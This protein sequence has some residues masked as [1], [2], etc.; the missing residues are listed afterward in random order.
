MVYLKEDGSLDI[1]RI[2]SLPLEKHL[3]SYCSESDEPTFLSTTFGVIDIDK[4]RKVISYVPVHTDNIDAACCSSSDT[5]MGPELEI[6]SVFQRQ[7]GQRGDISP[8]IHAFKG[9]NDWKFASKTDEVHILW[10]IKLVAEKFVLGY[11]S[12]IVTII[13]KS[14]PINEEIA[15][16]INA[17]ASNVITIRNAGRRI[18]TQSIV[19]MFE[20]YGDENDI[21]NLMAGSNVLILDDE[22]SIGETLLRVC[23]VVKKRY[24][25]KKVIG[26]SILSKTG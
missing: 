10:Q 22:M 11:P 17:S 2:K 9:E 25:P 19:E 16:I 26:L 8:L 12:N 1:E 6:W 13:A 18:T 3:K 4:N 5:T 20:S 7:I 15:G 14:N 24:F 21:A 23:E